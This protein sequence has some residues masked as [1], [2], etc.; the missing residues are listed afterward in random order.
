MP[1]MRLMIAGSSPARLPRTSKVTWVC[2]ATL[3]V[4]AVPLIFSLVPDQ[5]PSTPL[6]P[7]S[8]FEVEFRDPV[9]L[10]L[11]RHPKHCTY[12]VRPRSDRQTD[13][14][15]STPQASPSITSGSGLGSH[16]KGCTRMPTTQRNATQRKAT[17][18]NATYRTAQYPAAVPLVPQSVRCSCS[19]SKRATAF[20]SLVHTISILNPNPNRTALGFVTGLRRW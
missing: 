13:R 4:L 7:E 1:R 5:P 2:L 6:P 20:P 19:S 10:A 9:G 16:E 11:T 18:R 12:P 3:G 17:Q 14:Q 15:T 8:E